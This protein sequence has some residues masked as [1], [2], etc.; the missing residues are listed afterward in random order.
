[1]A[2]VDSWNRDRSA[3]IRT[4]LVLLQGFSRGS[5]IVLRVQGVVAKE[6][7]Q[8]SVQRIATRLGSCVQDSARAAVLGGIAVLLDFEFLHRI[9]GSLDIGAALV[10][11]GDVEAV[12]K[13]GNHTAANAA[14]RG[15]IDVFRANAQHVAGA[16]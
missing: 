15:S 1:M 12:Q 16:R 6:F 3:D 11:L 10:L 7:Q 9:N 8:A 14:D 4:E 2:I 13:V 5:K